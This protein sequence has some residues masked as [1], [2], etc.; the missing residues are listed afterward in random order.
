MIVL[1]NPTTEKLKSKKNWIEGNKCYSEI[2]L[3]FHSFPYELESTFLKEKK[4]R[5][6]REGG[7]EREENSKIH[8]S[9]SLTHMHAET[10]N[11]EDFTIFSD[12]YSIGIAFTSGSKMR[13]L[14]RMDVRHS[15]EH[16]EIIK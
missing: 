1:Q 6:R 2:F 10:H 5:R 16:N 15:S 8:L 11:N 12:D 13:S 14:V 9:L 7:R 3:S 4:E